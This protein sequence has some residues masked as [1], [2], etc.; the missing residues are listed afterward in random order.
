MLFDLNGTREAS[1]HL[2]YRGT[3]G[4]YGPYHD[5]GSISSYLL[6]FVYFD[7]VSRL[8]ELLVGSRLVDEGKPSVSSFV[9][10]IT[11]HDRGAV[12]NS[13]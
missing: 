10:L 4:L 3:V 2:I 7:Q 13:L 1:P 8:F 5:V 12:G 6:S 9:Q 11:S